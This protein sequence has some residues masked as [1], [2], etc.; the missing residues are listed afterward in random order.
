MAEGTK[1]SVG[2]EPFRN[3]RSGHSGFTLIEVVVVLVI[4]AILAGVAY[5]SY[6][7]VI[8]KLKRVEAKAALVQAMQ[9][10][11]RYYMVHARYLPFSADSTDVEARKFKW[12]SGQSPSAS[13]YEIGGSACTG[14]S[15]QDCILL[16][17]TAGSARVDRHYHD[18]QC[19]VMTLSSTGATAPADK[20]CW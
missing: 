14:E 7:H 4:V 16:T 1:T 10:Q 5:P 3:L 18:P 15:F 11:E 12:Y 20:D 6:L 19:G 8:R 17:A 9:Q 13:A 2:Q